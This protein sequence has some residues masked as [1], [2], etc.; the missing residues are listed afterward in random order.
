MAGGGGR[1]G[2]GTFII[3]ARACWKVSWLRTQCCMQRVRS[4]SAAPG[5]TRGET[6]CEGGGGQTRISVAGGVG[7]RMIE[8]AFLVST[9]TFGRRMRKYLV[10][11]PN[12][13]YPIATGQRA[14]DRT[15]VISTSSVLLLYCTFHA[16]D[17]SRSSV[18]KPEACGHM[19]GGGTSP[20]PRNQRIRSEGRGEGNSGGAMKPADSEYFSGV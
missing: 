4:V 16:T 7:P 11:N 15:S 17:C 10:A 3:W 12:T 8:G 20:G 14:K 2:P 9:K 6:Y 19:G 5:S 18:C 1:A 13:M